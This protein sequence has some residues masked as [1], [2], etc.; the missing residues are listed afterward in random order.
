LY[1][2]LVRAPQEF[3]V[4]VPAIAKYLRAALP[5]PGSP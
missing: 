5:P 1:R 3:T 2:D 4:V